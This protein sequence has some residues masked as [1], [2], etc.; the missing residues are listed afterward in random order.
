MIR[1]ATIQD[2]A[3][4]YELMAQLENEYFEKNRFHEILTM[5]LNHPDH[6]IFVYEDQ[7]VLG[8]IHLR[9]ELQLHHN[10]WVCELMECVTDENARSQGV[11]KALIQFAQNHVLEK[12]I[13]A[14]ELTSGRQRTRAHAFYERLGFK[15]THVK[16]VWTKESL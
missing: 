10:D 7:T 9:Y 16:L 4:I 8:M 12:G 3:I 13:Q 1:K 5:T 6:E 15:N 14:I 11:G 2:E